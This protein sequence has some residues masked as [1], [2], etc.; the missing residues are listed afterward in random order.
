MTPFWNGNNADALIIA[1]ELTKKYPNFKL[2]KIIYADLLSSYLEKKPLLGSVSKDK[3]LNDLK[4]EAKARINFNSVYKKKDLLP[5]SIIKL[6]DN[7]PYAF[8]I[9]LS[10]SRLYLIKNNIWCA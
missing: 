9:E 4:S 6:A 10:K 5:R 7:T 3:R 8:L 1:E 2:G